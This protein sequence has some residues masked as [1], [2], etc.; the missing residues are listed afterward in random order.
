MDGRPFSYRREIDGLRA[1]A[2]GVVILFHAGLPIL[3]G[4]F[5]GVDVFFVISGY[6]IT[7]I[8]LIDLSQDRFSIARFYERRARR[9]L[10][11]LFVVILASLPFAWA[12]MLP[13]QLDGFGQSVI[14]AVLSVSNILFWWQSGYFGP[15]AEEMPLLHTWS[16]GVEEQFYVLFPLLLWLLWRRAPRHLMLVMAALLAGSLALAELALQRDPMLA[17]YWLPFRAWELLAGA[18]CALWL[19]HRPL[20]AHGPLALAGI[21]LILGSAVVMTKSTPF[22]GVYALAPV[23]G[24]VAVVLFAGPST[25]AGRL[26]GTRVMVGIGLISY[27]AYLW[28]QPLFAFA[29]LRTI[30]APSGLTMAGLVAATFVLAWVSW[31]WVEQPFRSGR[32]LL[33]SRSAVFAAS[34]ANGAALLAVGGALVLGQGFPSRVPAGT[35][36]AQY[37]ATAVTSPLR[38]T[39]HYRQ[40]DQRGVSEA[41]RLFDLPPRVAVLGDSHGVSLSYALA[42]ALRPAGLG[43]VQFT[44]S[45]CEPSLT[46][47]HF[48]EACGRWTDE[49]IAWLE[50]TP[51][52]SH[53]VV[54]YRVTYHLSELGPEVNAELE[55]ILDR[56]ART[57]HVIFLM[58]SPELPDDVQKIAH[59]LSQDAG[60]GLPGA[61]RLDWDARRAPFERFR[62]VGLSDK[63]VVDPTP[64]FCNLHACIAGRDGLAFYT[65]DHHLSLG[66]A[67]LVVTRLL[68]LLPAP[69]L[70][71]RREN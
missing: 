12:W 53:V 58:Q 68:P 9:I 65:D 60:S 39:C 14:A 55:Q 8:L 56:L 22:P 32:P 26:L 43:V 59:L 2:V 33:P 11:A 67:R 3:P 57:K 16:L 63:V 13:E 47:P 6:L 50:G 70:L 44:R 38:D 20:R 62:Q 52:V 17:F 28:H 54:T 18:L 4:G 64:L 46:P 24:T 48:N 37:L 66:G 31:R 27:S 30:G 49:A 36:E 21:L 41:C 10:P 23:A 29:R 5:V 34:A 35:I 1:I 51:Q 71:S 61:S 25:L 42:E 15:E 69:E 19:F 45:S 7:S 40:I